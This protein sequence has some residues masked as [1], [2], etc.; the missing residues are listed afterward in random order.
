MRTK[1]PCLAASLLL[2]LS[3]CNKVSES[4][5]RDTI[6]TPDSISFEIP[7]I[8]DL[9]NPNIDIKDLETEVDLA[10]EIADLQGERFEPENIV[11]IRL[12][13][14]VIDLM[15]IRSADG[16]RDSIDAKNNFAN[17]GNIRVNVTNGAKTDSLARVTNSSN[18]LLA[19]FNL[20]PIISPDSL[21][22]YVNT[23]NMK[24]NLVVRANT[25]TTKTMKAKIA[26]T[27]IL[28]LRK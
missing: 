16:K 11:S 25:P 23:A 14:M 24:Y 28:T 26:A 5:Q 13:S 4:I 15:P 21:R 19:K 9:N 8:P 12:N 2:A 22:G 20:T 18:T 7:V 10:K 17:I 6:I 27:Y 3:A 1:F